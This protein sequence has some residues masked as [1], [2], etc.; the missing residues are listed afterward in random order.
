[1]TDPNIQQEVDAVVY[2]I[3]QI[4]ADTRELWLRFAAAQGEFPPIPKSKSADVKNRDGTAVL[5]SY[6]Y[7]DI[8]DVMA[9]VRPVLSK[10]GLAFTQ[11]LDVTPNTH[12]LVTALRFGTA[13]H[14]STVD[15]GK[16]TEPQQWGGRL[17]YLRRYAACALLGV[18][19]EDDL[20]A[21]HVRPTAAPAA[22]NTARQN[23]QRAATERAPQHDD[24]GFPAWRA[25]LVETMQRADK[26]TSD[27]YLMWI[28]NAGIDTKDSSLPRSKR[29]AV[30]RWVEQ[31][32]PS[33][34]ERPN[35]SS[36]PR[37]D[38]EAIAAGLDEE[39]EPGF[40][41]DKPMAEWTDVE[42][43]A[44]VQ[45][46]DDEA[47]DAEGHDIA[48]WS[49][50]WGDNRKRQTLMADMMRTRDALAAEPTAAG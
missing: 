28:A 48:E 50:R 5:Y 35:G 18:A 30:R 8:A 1:M 32:V 21:Q 33:P 49:T 38:G 20:D 9:M 19:A 13:C 27:A 39:S 37:D 17:T 44:Y 41:N 14:E 26:D 36:D 3:E 31:H 2:G 29:E 24:E 47:L 22:R 11:S 42:I 12:Y 16:P 25:W 4:A 10:H 46:L 34:F 6:D 40:D 7:A 45:A 23:T 43:L 15:L